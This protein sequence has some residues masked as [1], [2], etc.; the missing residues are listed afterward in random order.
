MF[1]VAV[2][3]FAH[4]PVQ[5][6]I[7]YVADFRNAPRWQRGLTAVE[8][9]GPFPEARKVVEVRR[10][11]GRRIEAPGELVAWETGAGFTVRGHS[12][13]L[14]VESRYGFAPE[15]DGTRISLNLTMS[16]LGPVRVMEPVLRR[17]LTRELDTAFKLLAVTLDG[18]LDGKLDG[19]LDGHGNGSFEARPVPARRG[20]GGKGLRDK[21]AL[22]TGASRGL[23]YL[24]AR[25]LAR[26]GCQ[27][28]LCARTAADLDRA[29]RE[30]GGYGVK[31][32]TMACDISD[33]AQAADFVRMAVAEL[34]PP[35]ILVNNASVMRVGPLR[36]MDEADFQEA[37]GVMFW[38]TVHTTL[39]ALAHMRERA[40]GNIVNI[41]SIGGKLSIP[42]LLPY[43]CAKSAMVS[44]SEGL[45]A[46]VADDGI[47]VTT[48][49]PGML[50][51]GSHLRVVYKG[52]PAREFAWFA[53]GSSVPMGSMDARRAARR[54]V[55]AMRHGRT[56]V[57]LPRS[58]VMGVWFQALFPRTMAV[59]MHRV[60]RLLPQG[61][62]AA[63]ADGLAI[64]GQGGPRLP[65]WATRLNDGAAREFNQIPEE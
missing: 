7:D 33:Q 53:A 43:S 39:A 5:T 34:G 15:A 18:T 60:N 23:G 61:S 1:T 49:L 29:A 27:V 11:L 17:S 4:V 2:S 58:A 22:V 10:F 25:E 45:R 3:A 64:Q 38:G 42:H 54:I 32:V 16:A 9:D 12:G 50:R 24:I 30:L 31:V 46:E 47:R 37:L 40:S 55:A 51:T 41:A 21:T 28:A 59:A 52:E 44:F 48:V 35:D 62:G 65:R 13:P 36:A 56:L 19:S 63:P 26:N 20:R 8:V 6:A 14:R 57:V